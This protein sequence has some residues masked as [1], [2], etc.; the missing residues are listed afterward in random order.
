MQKYSYPQGSKDSAAIS[1]Q[2]VR[3]DRRQNISQLHILLQKIH[4]QAA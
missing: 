2:I 4:H 3:K 1:K